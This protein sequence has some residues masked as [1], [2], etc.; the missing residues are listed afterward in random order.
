[1]DDS[2]ITCDEIIDAEANSYD[3]VKKAISTNFN[4]KK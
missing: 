4:D 1:M 3:E 2:V